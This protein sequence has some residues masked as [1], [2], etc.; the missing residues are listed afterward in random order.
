MNWYSV[1]GFISSFALFIPILLMLVL[2]LAPYRTFPALFLYYSSIF[3]YNLLTEG[4]IHADKQLIYYWGIINNLLDVPLMMIFLTYFSP[5]KNYAKRMHWFILAY[6]AF[7]L[8]IISVFGLSIKAITIILGPGIIMVAVFCMLFFGRNA[9]IAIEFKKCVGKS[10]IAA[11]LLFAYGCYLMIYFIFYIFRTKY[12]DDTF[13]L[14]FM[15][16]TF[17]AIFMS[18]GLYYEKKRV[19]K[20]QELLITRKEL[21][22]FYKHEKKAVP[23]R[24]AMLDIENDILC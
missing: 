14:Y 12:V 1:M 21:S 4:Y 6:V 20:L 18:I 5:T 11:S 3:F 24:T 23:I 22:E 10:F 17:S 16:S 2:R 7:E 15:A 8:V 13:L 9:K 19:K